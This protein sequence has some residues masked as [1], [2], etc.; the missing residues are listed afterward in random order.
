MAFRFQ[1]FP[2][3]QE[4]VRGY[5]WIAKVMRSFPEDYDHLRSQ[6]VRAALSVALNIAEGSARSS[7][8]DFRRFLGHSLGSVS[9]VVA[10]L[11]IARKLELITA[12]D[13]QHGSELYESL[14]KQLGGFSKSL[15][16]G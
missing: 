15:R 10:T 2:V 7:D 3:Y 9:E 13:Y 1:N 8:K 14:A 16:N 4:A 5:V 11:E 12:D 6:S